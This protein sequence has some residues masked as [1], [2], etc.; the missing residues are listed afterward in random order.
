MY[1]LLKK[2]IIKEEFLVALIVVLMIF[3]SFVPDIY[4][5][6]NRH[7]LVER[8]QWI[9]F[10]NYLYDYNSYLSKMK[11]GEQGRWTVVEKYT[12]EP[13]QGSLYQ[14]LYLLF[15]KIGGVFGFSVS[16]THFSTRI[17]LG[18]TWLVVIYLFLSL[19]FKEK[20]SRIACFLVILLNS[21][22]LRRLPWTLT[23]YYDWWSEFNIFA[24]PT[25][26][27]HFL[28]SHITIALS[29]LFFVLS[30]KEK[31]PQKVLVNTLSSGL[32]ALIGGLVLPPS[33]LTIYGSLALF[34][35]GLLLAGRKEDFL[36]TLKIGLSVVLISLPSVFYFFALF[37]HYPWKE[38]AD[39]EKA[40]PYLVDFKMY[41]F[42]Q[43]TIFLV[44]LLA[45]G[46]WLIRFLL[47]K[48]KNP[49]LLL[50]VGWFITHLLGIWWL[51]LTRAYLSLRFWQVAAFVPAGILAIWLVEEIGRLTK[52]RAVKV[53]LLALIFLSFLPGIFLNFKYII[54]R[55]RGILTYDHDPVPY[56]TQ[57]HYPLKNLMRAISWLA[58]NTK[59]EEIVLAHITVGNFIPAYAGN[60]VYLGNTTQTVKIKEKHQQAT[61]FFSGKFRP[62]EAEDFLQENAIRFV[63]WGPQERYWRGDLNKYPFLEKVYE[64]N[65]IIIFE[66][67][68]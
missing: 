24:R 30:F 7:Q 14:I 60:T 39:W 54:N 50:P 8:R 40:H 31:T 53:F 41:A 33:L 57:E 22:Y 51:N 36:K 38:I 43:G 6:L 2:L 9:Y 4:S 47:R 58:K 62:K 37:S 1:R 17:S 34:G 20:F 23:T 12:S 49:F 44:A 48:E 13:H 59:P 3:L 28:V 32:L 42:S 68:R 29:L 46:V 18:M 27:P 16:L 11:Q 55:E 45:I 64:N 63:F 52:K 56:P 10:H 19:F 66:V 15:G 61:D 26:L 65:D 25:F 21:S 67:K 5:F 35:L